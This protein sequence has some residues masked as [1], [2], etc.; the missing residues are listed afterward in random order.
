MATYELIASNTVGSG[1]A[2]SITFSSIPSTYTDLKV[3]FSFRGS[4]SGANDV[5]VSFNGSTANYTSLIVFGNGA[6][7]SSIT[8]T[9]T[10]APYAGI[11][12]NSSTTASTFSSGELYIPNYTVSGVSKSFSGEAVSENNATTAVTEL[13]ANIWTDT[14]A[15]TSVTLSNPSGDFVQHSTAYLYGIKN[16]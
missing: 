15:I 11:Q 2:S 5:R 13:G 10:F 3:V 7:A 6:T 4:V 16:S 1:G 9:S 12:N 8:L 14:G